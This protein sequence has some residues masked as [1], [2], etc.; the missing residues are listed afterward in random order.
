MGIS[1]P[2]RPV[3]GS[4]LFSE[5]SGE[6]E[7]LKDQV[8]YLCR[9]PNAGPDHDALFLTPKESSFLDAVTRHP[10]IRHPGPARVRP[11]LRIATHLGTNGPSITTSELRKCLPAVDCSKSVCSQRISPVSR[12]S[13]V[14]SRRLPPR[15]EEANTTQPPLPPIPGRSEGL[16]GA[17]HKR[18]QSSTSS[19][20]FLPKPC[21]PTKQPS[22]GPQIRSI[23]SQTLIADNDWEALSNKHESNSSIASGSVSTPATSVSSPD[24]TTKDDSKFE[25]KST[26]SDASS[27]SKQQALTPSGESPMALAPGPLKI[28]K[29]QPTR[30]EDYTPPPGPPSTP[31][32]PKIPPRSV[33]R[34]STTQPAVRS[35]I[36]RVRPVRL[37]TVQREYSPHQYIP[38]NYHPSASHYRRQHYQH[39]HHPQPRYTPRPAAAYQPRRFHSYHSRFVPSQTLPPI[40]QD[41]D[42]AVVYPNSRRPRSSR[43]GQARPGLVGDIGGH[44]ITRH[45]SLSLSAC[46]ST[47]PEERA[48][49]DAMVYR[50]AERTSPL[51]YEGM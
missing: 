28:H 1:G 13:S 46:N 2:K 43:Y 31:S 33:H 5:S 30:K 9:H 40:P 22:D 14:A 8:F 10:S 36:P 35:H 42:V 39:L 4:S 32:V 16:Y 23:S 45:T 25:T 48:A 51:G 20:K 49:M 29:T 15:V 3:R 38:Q 41:D 18:Q 11:E 50:G 21:A 27:E 26:H 34:R 47:R 17:K 24:P 7:R 6:S 44:G 19:N 37:S 12:N